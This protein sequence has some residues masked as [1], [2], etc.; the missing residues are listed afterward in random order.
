MEFR[1][2][3]DIILDENLI[4]EYSQA[5]NLHPD[6]IRL[7]QNRGLNS[8]EQISNFL[9]PPITAFSDPYLL[10]DMDK[11]VNKIKMAITDKKRIVVLGDYDTDGI[12]ASAILFKYFKSKG[13]DVNVFLPNRLLD[14]YGLTEDTLDKI[15]ALY[16]PNLIITV[17]C[18]ISCAN[19]VEYC[20]NK[21]VDIIVTDHHDIPEILPK[22]LIINAKLPNQKY[23]FKEL[24]GAGVAFKLVQ[25]LE[26]VEEALKYV[27]IA[28]IATV[29]D[30]V[31][32][33]GE[34]RAI[35]Y[36][37]L[38]N[39][40]NLPYG[41]T[42]LCKNLK[43]NLPLSSTDIAY[44]LAPKINASG[45]MGDASVSF[46]LYVEE[47]KKLVT[48]HINELLSINENRVNQTNIIYES[49]LKKLENVNIS[50]LG[51]IMLYDESWESGVLG[52]ICSKLVEKFNKPV[53]L[54]S[55][56][57]GEFKGS[58]RSITGISITDILNKLK[59]LL[60]RFGGHNQAGGLSVSK[61]NIDTFCEEFNREVLE[62]Y[63][64]KLLP[65]SKTYDLEITQNISQQFLDDL[66]MLE[67]FGMG[68]EV[69]VFKITLPNNT[70]AQRMANYPNHL[71]LKAYNIEILG[72]SL[73]DYY[74][75]F[76]S[77]CKKEL[78]CNV[79]SE[80]Y[81]KHKQIKANIKAMNFSPLSTLKNKEITTANYL[82]TFASKLGATPQT[83][84]KKMLVSPANIYNQI[85]SL[86]SKNPFGTLV[87][88]NNF[89][90]YKKALPK[91]TNIYNFELYNINDEKGLNTLILAPFST[92]N[93]KNY[94]NVIFLDFPLCDEYIN[95]LPNANIYAINKP[96]PFNS[97]TTISGEHSVFASFHNGIKNA[98][99]KGIKSYNIYG[100]FLQFKTL[101]P[102]IQNAKFEQ[103][104][105]VYLVLSELNIIS[106]TNEFELIYNHGVKTQ[107]TNSSI[108]NAIVNLIKKEK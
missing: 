83:N 72:F 53:C 79:Y 55:V 92:K 102:Q 17:D 15:F 76:N 66:Q 74:N 1:K 69:P 3:T 5:F 51:A 6:V 75:N 13:I 107:L 87:V 85:N 38:K 22:T 68:N 32:L 89:E 36:Y 12:S 108:Y 16:N 61:E 86:T 100:Y 26:G 46:K 90:S 59:H 47:N 50:T 45:R 4:K 62:N 11:V 105:F 88:I 77:N 23:P 30:I 20:L 24:C 106:K 25:A 27:T 95:N 96:Y 21:G 70:L 84:T 104:M 18:G 78:L 41:L 39:Q 7:L 37:G 40:Q 93:F 8:K 81:N 73:G 91:L 101:N 103:F 60:I 71:K 65:A 49:A 80:I 35:V 58:C 94:T 9:N 98:I 48:E 57:D 28:S 14:G 33:V 44:K 67:P 64:D 34:N 56:V 97:F 42:Q 52:I 54:M 29:A 43:I 2:N 19:E 82:H 99:T 31:P 10:N 63:S